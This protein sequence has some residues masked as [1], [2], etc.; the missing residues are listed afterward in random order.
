ML[1]NLKKNKPNLSKVTRKRLLEMEDFLFDFYKKMS[2]YLLKV[3]KHNSKS[4]E[5][6]CRFHSFS[7]SISHVR[8]I[9][10]HV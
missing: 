10:W 8:L 1:E 5:V 7:I 4:Y 3:K 6:N 2:I 9:W